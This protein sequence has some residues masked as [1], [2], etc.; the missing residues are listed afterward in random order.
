MCVCL[1]MC[2]CQQPG[3]INLRTNNMTLHL[4]NSVFLN[5]FS[6]LLLAFCPFFKR[7][8]IT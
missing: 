4:V 3:L 1:C 2:V 8:S 7:E 5:S 6:G